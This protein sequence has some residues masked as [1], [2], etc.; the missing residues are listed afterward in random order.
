MY[1][2]VART[3]QEAL[4][5]LAVRASLEALKLKWTLKAQVSYE[6]TNAKTKS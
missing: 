6:L 3:A 1:L 2:Y 5:E 4:A